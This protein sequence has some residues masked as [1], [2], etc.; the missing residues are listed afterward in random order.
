MSWAAT[1]TKRG[2]QSFLGSNLSELDF[3]D[4][5]VAGEPRLILE[6]LK[7]SVRNFKSQRFRNL[8]EYF[9]FRQAL[10]DLCMFEAKENSYLAM[11]RAIRFFSTKLCFG[12]GH[13]PSSQQQC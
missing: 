7:T 12:I 2:S 11:S 10:R 6:M 8:L 1:Q 4:D 5:T 13:T 3:V 9:Y